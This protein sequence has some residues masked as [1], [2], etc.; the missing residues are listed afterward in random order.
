MVTLPGNSEQVAVPTKKNNS[1]EEN[2]M[3]G[4]IIAK[5]NVRA[6]IEALN[7]R[8]VPAFLKDWA[9]N[10]VW[11]YPGVLPVGGRFVG[12]K[13][14]KGWFENLIRQMPQLKFTVHS[15]SVSNVF[16]LAGNNT[17]AA[18]WEV[19]FTNRDGYRLQY[20]GVAVLTIKGGKVVEGTDFLFAMDDRIGR[21]WGDSKPEA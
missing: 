13:A 10:A 4:S 6:A 20:S 7:R 5:K 21:L 9:D 14:I 16:D 8:D 11:N 1:K 17:A 19:D 3:I 2:T 18:H 15:V 12:K